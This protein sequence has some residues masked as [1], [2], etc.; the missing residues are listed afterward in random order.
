MRST[1]HGTYNQSGSHPRD[2]IRKRRKD[3]ALPSYYSFFDNTSEDPQWSKMRVPMHDDKFGLRLKHSKFLQLT[4]LSKIS[5]NF[6]EKM[7]RNVFL[8]VDKAS[9]YCLDPHLYKLT[10]FY[11]PSTSF[12]PCHPTS[13]KWRWSHLTDDVISTWHVARVER[14]CPIFL[15]LP[16]FIGTPTTTHHVDVSLRG[17]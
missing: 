4:R 8:D 16:T 1:E 3:T 10:I 17:A 6:S 13:W 15:R 14:V 5:R 12:K 11:L 9:G 2:L 7:T